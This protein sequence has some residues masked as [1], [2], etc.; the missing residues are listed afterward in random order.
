METEWS[1][2]GSDGSSLHADLTL[3]RADPRLHR[4]VPIGDGSRI[5]DELAAPRPD[6]GMAARSLRGT[7]HKHV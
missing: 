7:D 6:A 1:R 3:Q 5:G 2:G 4:E